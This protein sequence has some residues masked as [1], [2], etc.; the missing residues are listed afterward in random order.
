[1]K[2]LLLFALLL[3]NCHDECADSTG[4][5]FNENDLEWFPYEPGDSINYKDASSGEIYYLTCETREMGI[6]SSYESFISSERCSEGGYYY[7]EH[8]LNLEFYSNLP[9]T[10]APLYL[11]QY[12]AKQVNRVDIN[13]LF[14]DTSPY[15]DRYNFF[16]NEQTWALESVDRTSSGIYFKGSLTING[17]VYHDVYLISINEDDYFSETLFYDSIYYN[18]DGFLK[19]ISTNF[20]YRL[21][22]IE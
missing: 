19:F 3:S 10:N 1:M 15:P 22:I 2:L 17:Q 13:I 20:N 14:Y 12:M 21:E 7:Y 5:E 11:V 16:L 18:K 9:N 8:Y 6:D 4:P